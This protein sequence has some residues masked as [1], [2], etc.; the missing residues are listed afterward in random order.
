LKRAI[1]VILAAISVLVPSVA[2]ASTVNMTL[3]G[4]GS[5]VMAGIYMGPYTALIDGQ[6]FKVICDDFLSDTY[7]NE[8]WTATVSTFS[9]LTTTKFGET[10][11]NNYEDAAWLAL[12]LLD[13]LTSAA[14]AASIQFAIWQILT[15][16]AFDWPLLT[17]VQ[18]AAAQVWVNLARAQN[19]TQ[20]QFANI[21]FYTPTG[22]GS[23][24]NNGCPSTVPQE[25]I[26]VRSVPE[27]ATVLMLGTG[28]VGV[29]AARRRRSRDQP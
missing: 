22:P 20:G 11:R 13:P 6:S 26:G 25:F 1:L 27:P 5:N 21:V 17:D 16:T 19:Y 4:A 2:S 14:Q 12:K 9:D 7:L 18:Q 15:P 8:S 10:N 23:C 29:V 24:P 3:T 28:L